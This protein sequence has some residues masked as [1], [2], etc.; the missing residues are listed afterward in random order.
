MTTQDQDPISAAPGAAP[1]EQL[2]VSNERSTVKVKAL[3]HAT[4]AGDPGS[5]QAVRK[6]IGAEENP[7]V[8]ATMASVLGRA[9]TTGGR[10]RPGDLVSTPVAPPPPS[11]GAKAR[12]ALAVGLLGAGAWMGLGSGTAPEAAT[13]A[14]RS[15]QLRMAKPAVLRKTELP[16]RMIASASLSV[17]AGGAG[18]RVTAADASALWREPGVADRLGPVGAPVDVEGTVTAVSPGRAVLFCLGR[19]YVV[20]GHELDRKPLGSKMRCR[21]KISGVAMNGLIYV[22][23][24]FS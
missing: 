17:A 24:E 4:R 16:T 19:Y 18:G 3:V 12:W 23:T 1:L 2:L 7:F 6:H 20:R 8:L 14:S 9:G 10:R 21:G 11:A 13:T 5:A 22:D 15:E